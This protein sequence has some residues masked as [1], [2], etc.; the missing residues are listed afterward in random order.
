M[1][2]EL[3]PDCEDT[4]RDVRAGAV[5]RRTHSARGDEVDG[6]GSDE[7]VTPARWDG[8][9]VARGK[10]RVR[11]LHGCC[12]SGC[13]LRVVAEDHHRRQQRSAGING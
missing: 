7:L 8:G 10:T 3:C 13:E 2:R 12:G 6:G 1:W 11:E 4:A 5:D 9:A